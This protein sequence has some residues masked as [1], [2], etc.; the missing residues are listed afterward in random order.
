[1]PTTTAIDRAE[2]FSYSNM[3]QLNRYMCV[4]LQNGMMPS[5]VR[6]L[7]HKTDQKRAT[8]RK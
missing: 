3:I 1:M 5:I 6:I 7:A 8:C 2:I 4:I